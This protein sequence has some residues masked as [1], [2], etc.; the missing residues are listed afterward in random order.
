MIF[1]LNGSA[2]FLDESGDGVKNGRFPRAVRSDQ[3]DDLVSEDG[4]ID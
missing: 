3:A 1:K 2:L 4:E